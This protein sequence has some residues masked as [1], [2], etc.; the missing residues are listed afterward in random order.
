MIII[1]SII[2][3]ILLLGCT[4]FFN[5]SL[6]GGIIGMV[7]SLS[8]AVL[9]LVFR[10]KPQKKAV[11]AGC[12]LLLIGAV[13]MGIFF[14]TDTYIA[15]STEE[16]PVVGE[17]ADAAAEGDA[18]KGRKIAAEYLAEREKDISENSA[19]DHLPDDDT[20]QLLLAQCCLAV[21]DTSGAE[22]ALKEVKNKKT[23]GY[24]LQYGEYARQADHSQSFMSNWQEAV[25]EY[26]QWEISNLMYGISM[27]SAAGESDRRYFDDIMSTAYLFL[28]RAYD[29]NPENPYTSCYLGV[30]NCMESNYQLAIT[31]LEQAQKLDKG[32]DEELTQTIADYIEFTKK[33]GELE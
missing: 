14:P 20:I 10:K 33:E 26:P 27:V 19:P 13:G 25:R 2:V 8:T 1:L 16:S 29:I 23:Q 28:G 5:G 21:G 15:S 3:F 22:E 18:V 12:V 17:L 6:I 11:A 31:Y 4:V 24:Y 9:T 30:A 32:E 7:L